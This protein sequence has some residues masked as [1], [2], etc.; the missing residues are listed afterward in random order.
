MI[1]YTKSTKTCRYFPHV[2]L[3]RRNMF[4]V[5]HRPAAS[6]DTTIYKMDCAQEVE[7][8]LLTHSDVIDNTLGDFEMYHTCSGTY[9]FGLAEEFQ[10]PSQFKAH[11][12]GYQYLT[13]SYCDVPFKVFL[14]KSLSVADISEL[15]FTQDYISKIKPGAVATS[16]GWFKA[17]DI[18]TCNNV[19]LSGVMG[20]FPPITDTT[21]GIQFIVNGNVIKEDKDLVPEASAN[22]VCGRGGA[23]HC[24]HHRDYAK[25]IGISEFPTGD[26]SVNASAKTG[27]GAG[28]GIVLGG[29]EL[30]IDAPYKIGCFDFIDESFKDQTAAST[31][32]AKEC[33]VACID[34]DMRFAAVTGGTNCL[35][36]KEF[37]QD[38]L[39]PSKV[40]FSANNFRLHTRLSIISRIFFRNAMLH[41]LKRALLNVGAMCPIHFILQ[42]R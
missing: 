32:T 41:V 8:N 7:T 6:I 12:A 16:Y 27:M 21:L 20:C 28:L 24:R 10:N 18:A 5:I 36:F 17:G 2:S 34:Q 35:C 25:I 42:V 23:E 33:L 13:M 22:S 38:S 14:G 3:K 9:K 30:L 39:L 31:A 40:L 11:M 4:E 15:G 37:P 26:V 1:E 19:T 29:T